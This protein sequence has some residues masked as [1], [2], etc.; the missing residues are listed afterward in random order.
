MTEQPATL[1]EDDRLDGR[2]SS[3]FAAS[4]C[5]YHALKWY[6]RASHLDEDGKKASIVA[7]R[8]A[9]ASD[10]FRSWKNLNRLSRLAKCSESDPYPS[11]FERR[12]TIIGATR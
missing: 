4:L 8:Y 2:F 11:P 9:L 1:T 12:G 10:S 5:Q 3:V 7:S 6:S